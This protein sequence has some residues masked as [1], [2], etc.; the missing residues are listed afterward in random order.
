MKTIYPLGLLKVYMPIFLFLLL[1]QISAFG[2]SS[3]LSDYK[4]IG[5]YKISCSYNITSHLIFP[6]P[7]VYVDL[8]S[9]GIIAEKVD[10]VENILRVKGNSVNFKP[11][12]LTVIT[13]HGHYYSFLVSYE[14]KPSEIS[15]RL[16]D[17]PQSGSEPQ[18]SNTSKKFTSKANHKGGKQ[19]RAVD[20]YPQS[21][22]SS[23]SLEREIPNS[24]SAGTYA[25]TITTTLGSDNTI[26]SEVLI[27][28]NKGRAAGSAKG[29]ASFEKIDYSN[30]ELDS[31]SENII[32]QRRS[33]DNIGESKNQISFSLAGLYIINNAF[34]FHTITKNSSNIDFDI[35]MIRVNVKDK[36]IAKR[37]AQQDI[38]LQP[39]Y[40]YTADRKS[41]NGYVIP[42]ERIEGKSAVNKVIVLEKFTIPDAKVLSIE[43]F[44]KNGGRHISFQVDNET[45]I[46]ARKLETRG[47]TYQA[48]K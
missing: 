48:H 32:S 1:F 7:I 43:L 9:S 18:A 45:I 34:M 8:G 6:A 12:N 31:F 23:S 26:N 4:F 11:T 22:S 41:K 39:V 2:Q 30:A 46:R 20:P 47:S 44:E 21:A 29:L 24:S 19:A 10:K 14:E 33:I 35:D 25:T 28:G 36:E 38:E 13:S 15:I 3:V 40:I 5:S 16:Q 37:T 27:S 17:L 42:D